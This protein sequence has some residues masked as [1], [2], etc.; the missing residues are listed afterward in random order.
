[1]NIIGKILKNL[2]NEEYYVKHLQIINPLLPSVSKMTQ[3][4]IEVLAGFMSLSG[5]L[6]DKNRF[7]TSARK[8]V[9]SKLNISS[10]GLGNY[11]KSFKN[12]NLIF[13]NDYGVLELK[14][15]L[16]PELNNQGYKIKI[17]K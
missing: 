4:E 5:D 14:E 16:I 3:K 9:M 12:K 1:M 13:I 15:F 8:E 2:G 11:L 7:G 6:V 10:G 17:I